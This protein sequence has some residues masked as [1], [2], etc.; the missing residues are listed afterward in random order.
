MSPQ[1]PE[2]RDKLAGLIQWHYRPEKTFKYADALTELCGV[3]DAVF[4]LD[5]QSKEPINAVEFF[6]KYP[7]LQ[8]VLRCDERGDVTWNEWVNR[9]QLLA[10]AAKHHC[11]FALWLDDDEAFYPKATRKDFEE[12]MAKMNSNPAAT[13]LH[14]PSLTLW[15]SPD[16]VRM[17]GFWGVMSKPVLQKNPFFISGCI[18]Y[19]NNALHRLHCWP[20]SRGS[21]LTA[22]TPGVLHYGLIDPKDRVNWKVKYEKHDANGEF[23]QMKADDWDRTVDESIANVMTLE[24]AYKHRQESNQFIDAL[25]L[26]PI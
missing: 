9:N 3:C 1:L 10:A 24:D 23:I 8:A 13:S 18:C 17:D 12:L 7:K 26:N 6:K 19:P 4:V 14:L 16:C 5:D 2:L 15:N 20:I 25:T 21:T 11:N 22:R